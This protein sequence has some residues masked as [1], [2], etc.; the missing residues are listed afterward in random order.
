M[1]QRTD[2]EEAAAEV[3]RTGTA[4]GRRVAV[5]AS[6]LVLALATGAGVGCG[7]D[8]NEGPAEEAGQ[9]VDDAGSEAEEAIEDADKEI[10]DDKD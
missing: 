3:S 1:D 2:P 7:D 9:A 5:V 6:T 8:D 4:V 10:G